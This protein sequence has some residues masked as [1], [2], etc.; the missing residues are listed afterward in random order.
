MSGQ[1]ARRSFISRLK[2][3]FQGSYDKLYGT[4]P[5]TFPEI[6]LE[7][8]LQNLI[9]LDDDFWDSRYAFS[10]DPLGHLV[11]SREAVLLAHKARECGKELAKKMLLEYGS[12]RVY[13]LANR[14]HLTIR[15]TNNAMHGGTV[16]FAEFIEPDTIRIYE[17]CLEKLSMMTEQTPQN[18]EV[19]IQLAEESL[20]SHEIFHVLELRENTIFT[21]SYA[22][23]LPPFL[24]FRRTVKF[25]CLGEIAAMAFVK[26]YLQLPFSPY[27]Y[28]LL[29]TY[30][31]N[32]TSVYRLYNR[33]ISLIGSRTLKNQEEQ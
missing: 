15:K 12:L 30:S 20:L 21:R 8:M 13:E 27:I 29:L 6:S 11:N 31:Y 19:M 24:F 4:E 2:L 9:T 14:M 28:D 26:E 7:A 23:L 18:I 5:Q 3:S 25:I 32:R 22:H 1:F 17:D 33:I 10:K 16:H